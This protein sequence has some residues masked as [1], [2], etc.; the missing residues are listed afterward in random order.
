MSMWKATILGA[1]QGLT[2]FIP[3]SSSGHLVIARALLGE[4]M[5]ET[6][7]QFD[8]AVHLGTLVAVVVYFRREALAVIRAIPLWARSLLPKS[9]RSPA[10]PKVRLVWM[11]IAATG[12]TGA[13]AFLLRD[14]VAGLEESAHIAVPVVA[15]LLAANGAF[16]IAGDLKREGSRE[17]GHLHYAWSALVGLAQGIAVFPGISRAGATITTGI[18]A[19]AKRESAARF[20]FLLAIPAIVAAAALEIRGSGSAEGVPVVATAVAAVVAAAFGL[21]AIRFLLSLLRTRRIWSFGVYCVALAAIILV[22]AA[23]GQLLL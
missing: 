4:R 11:L 23:S 20:S 3:V 21:L 7:L 22:L 5:G 12:A 13:I 2:E 16:L 6:G 8:V 10:E 14:V 17:L 1:L 15:G 18:L 9:E 19:G